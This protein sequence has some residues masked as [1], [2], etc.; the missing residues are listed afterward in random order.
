MYSK[1]LNYNELSTN[2]YSVWSNL[3]PEID[4]SQWASLC[5]TIGNL[6]QTEFTTLVALVNAHQSL[7]NAVKRQVEGNLGIGDGQVWSSQDSQE[8]R[9]EG[10]EWLKVHRPLLDAMLDKVKDPL[11]ETESVP[12]LEDNR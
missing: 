2:E 6:S 9:H 1:S 7:K 11:E 10:R 3:N 5:R 8:N 4:S 12:N